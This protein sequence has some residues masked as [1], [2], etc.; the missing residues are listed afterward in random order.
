MVAAVYYS[1]SENFPLSS[2]K[3][4]PLHHRVYE[5]VVTRCDTFSRLEKLP[6]YMV[7]ND[8]AESYTW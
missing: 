8:T 2:R 6:Y 3:C 7:V 4:Q 5:Q 1:Q